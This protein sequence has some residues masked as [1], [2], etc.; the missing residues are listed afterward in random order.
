[1]HVYALITCEVSLSSSEIRTNPIR[2]WNRKSGEYFSWFP[3]PLRNKKVHKLSGHRPPMCHTIFNVWIAKST[4]VST[5]LHPTPVLLKLNA[6]KIVAAEIFFYSFTV[7]QPDQIN[8]KPMH[9]MV[10]RNKKSTKWL[11]QA[12]FFTTKIWPKGSIFGRIF[13]LR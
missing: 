10:V 5:L 6:T 4:T 3:L 2:M 13:K 1:M 11:G 12:K 9:N 8:V 7:Y